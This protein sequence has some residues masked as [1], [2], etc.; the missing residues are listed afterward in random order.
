MGAGAAQANAVNNLGHAAGYSVENDG[1]AHATL[2]ESGIVEDLGPNTSANG[3]NDSDQIVGYRIDDSGFYHAHLWPDNIDLGSLPGFDSSVASG[4]NNSGLVVGIAF[5]LDDPD[6][7]TA[8]TWTQAEGMRALSSCA[9]ASAVNESGQIGGSATNLDAAICGEKD[10]GMTGGVGALNST[11]VAVGS[12]GNNA[13]VYPGT[14]LGPTSAIGINDNGWVIGVTITPTGMVR[15]RSHLAQLNPHIVGTAQAWIW[16]QESG[17]VMLP[18]LI[19]PSGINQSGQIVGTA[20][21]S[22]GSIHGGLLTGN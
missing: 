4:I 15:M 7:E 18:N 16:T 1:T 14:N 6:V 2:W 3:I 11:G 8:F 19:V 13:W 20:V 5:Q 10:F 21:E 17:M 12:A 22:D 9:T